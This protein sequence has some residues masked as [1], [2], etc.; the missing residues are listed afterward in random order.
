MSDNDSSELLLMFPLA[1]Y[2]AMLTDSDSINQTFFDN[3]ED[4]TFSSSLDTL[5]G[6][7]LGKG[8]IHHNPLFK[9]F[10]DKISEHATN[11]MA[12]L[13]VKT[14]IFD[15]FVNKCWLSI[16]D[17]PQ[18]NMSYHTHTVADISFV[19]YLQ[20]PENSDLISFANRHKQNEL[21]PNLLDSDRP[22][23]QTMLTEINSFNC[24]TYNIMPESGMLLMFPGKQSHGTIKNAA[25]DFNGTRIAVVGDISLFFKPNYENTDYGRLPFNYMRKI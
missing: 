5:T 7:F 15:L 24:S 13:G 21:F 16:I 19:Y 1:V 18:Y 17:T 8:N 2:K 25:G 14:D 9:P 10:F 3:I 20:I 6:D 22:L 11:Y 12:S 23:P 4:Y